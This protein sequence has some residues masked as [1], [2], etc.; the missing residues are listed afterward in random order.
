MT[1]RPR[2]QCTLPGNRYYVVAAIYTSFQINHVKSVSLAWGGNKRYT[3]TPP[4]HT[5]VWRV[6]LPV[7]YCAACIFN[8]RL[9]PRPWIMRMQP[10]HAGAGRVFVL[11][12]QL[13]ASGRQFAPV[14]HVNYHPPPP[15]HVT[16]ARD[17]LTK[18]CIFGFSMQPH[19]FDEKQMFS[20]AID[21]W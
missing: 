7:Y 13:K 9:A 4:T 1:T 15:T 16:R 14:E 10:V 5:A 19:C 8:T 3:T 12:G 18:W 17:E 20:H 21:S 6:T 11:N 2:I